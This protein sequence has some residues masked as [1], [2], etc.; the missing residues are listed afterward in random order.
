MLA[1]IFDLDGVIIDSMP[2]HTEAWEAYLD[3]HG[4][5]ADELV[6][7]MHGR[8]NDEIVEVFFGGGLTPVQIHDHGAAKEKLFREMMQPR[9][10]EHL[11]PGV[12]EFLE[13][14]AHV[15][16]GLASNAEPANI[17]STLDGAG[18]RRHFDVIVDGHQVQRPKPFPDIYLR[19]AQ[20]LGIPIGDCI[21]FED[22]PTGIQA[23]RD[24]GALVVGVK[25]HTGDLPPVDLMID[26]FHDPGLE[27]WLD[28]TGMVKPSLR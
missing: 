4:V 19:A 2:L 27:A 24:S 10:A 16:T 25:T 17:D 21:I 7:R 5:T 11:V 28:K 22:S 26:N 12:L 8:R 13:K 18:I 20:L 23:A 3:R 1:F 6:A 15:P 9:L 14:Y